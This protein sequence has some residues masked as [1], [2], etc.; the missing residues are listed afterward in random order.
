MTQRQEQR[1]E[2][3]LQSKSE[4]QLRQLVPVFSQLQ[5]C[6]FFCPLFSSEVLLPCPCVHGLI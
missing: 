6:P 1:H 2:P 3:D 4:G 5:T